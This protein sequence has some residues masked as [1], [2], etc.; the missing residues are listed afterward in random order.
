[1]ELADFGKL[2]DI[3]SPLGKTA[4]TRD[5]NRAAALLDFVDLEVD[6]DLLLLLA[7]GDE[8][9]AA[10]VQIRQENR[11]ALSLR[12]TAAGV[13][14][15]AEAVARDWE[16][17]REQAEG[18]EK[19][20]RKKVEDLGED[21]AGYPRP[22]V[23]AKDLEEEVSAREREHGAMIEA[24][25]IRVA[26]EEER[27]NIGDIGERPDVDGVR[28]RYVAQERE[29]ASMEEKLR[30][31]RERLEEIKSE[32]EEL[33][34]TA[35]KWDER[36]RRLD[37]TVE[38]PEEEDVEKMAILVRGLK[39]DLEA[40]RIYEQMDQEKQA[41]SEA[42]AEV[43]RFDR[44]ATCKREV[45]QGVPKKLNQ[46][47][48]EQDFGDLALD[49][50]EGLCM[51]DRATGLLEPFERLSDGERARA[52]L[53]G[54]GCKAYP[55]G[56][57]PVH[58]HFWHDLQPLRQRELVQIALEEDVCLISEHPTDDSGVRVVHLGE[59][60][61]SSGETSEAYALRRAQEIVAA[62]KLGGATA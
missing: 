6:D 3:I 13:K 19:T 50:E 33:A 23:T 11:P 4:A 61:V 35:K 39:A 34:A 14:R 18:K 30:A 62:R 59:E 2:A 17:R 7:Q 45:A 53:T 41:M 29:I 36:R 27:L 54:I 28:D 49:G 12:E 31:A 51:I 9:V 16:A 56:V 47:I 42:A 48:A 10:G 25:K 44:L 32:G 20:H 46:I 38:G 5:K 1:V 26:R 57:M 8:E 37:E 43:K 15:M 60:W 58:P 55:G 52:A 22:D 40:A 24:R 21:L